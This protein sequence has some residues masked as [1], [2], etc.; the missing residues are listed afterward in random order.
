ML[1]ILS[2]NIHPG[3]MVGNES[4]TA[5]LHNE[6]NVGIAPVQAYARGRKRNPNYRLLSRQM[7][8]GVQTQG[9]NI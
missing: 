5:L 3:N 6:Q 2:Y 8:C 9:G 4:L 1:C 7:Q